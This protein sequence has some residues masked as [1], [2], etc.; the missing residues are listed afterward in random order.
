MFRNSIE[1]KNAPEKNLNFD[2]YNFWLGKLDRAGGD[3]VSAE[4]VKAFITS[5][6][7]RARF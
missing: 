2:G 6:E 1:R 7:Y 3:F 5:D 4:M